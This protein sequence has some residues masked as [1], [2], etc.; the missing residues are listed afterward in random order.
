MKG[1]A[2][3]FKAGAWWSV[4]KANGPPFECQHG[5]FCSFAGRGFVGQVD[6]GGADRTQRRAAV[7]L[8][9][10]THGQG[11]VTIE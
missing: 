8:T 5:Q 2:K 1:A 3:F 9:S 7:P 10:V 4:K 11:E 6:R